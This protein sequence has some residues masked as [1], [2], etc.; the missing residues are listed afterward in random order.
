MKGIILAGGAGTRLHP[1]TLAVS[2]QLM[3]IFNKPMIHYP[4]STLMLAGIRDILVITTPMDV[5]LFERV[6]G[7]PIPG[8]FNKRFRVLLV[9]GICKR[10]GQGPC[11]MESVHSGDPLDVAARVPIPPDRLAIVRRLIRSPLEH[12]IHDPVRLLHVSSADLA[13]RFSKRELRP[14]IRQQCG[15]RPNDLPRSSSSSR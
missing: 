10:L 12:V 3:P 1:L 9:P 6:L 15:K 7:D 11:P 8:K 13:R 14:I 2:K 4:L 5:E